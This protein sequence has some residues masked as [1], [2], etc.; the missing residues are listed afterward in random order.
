M[1]VL[2]WREVKDEEYGV[3][4]NPIAHSW[5]PRLFKA[6]FEA[7]GLPYRYVA[8]QCDDNE[9][10][11]AIAFLSTRMKGLNVTAP[12]KMRV[13]L[14]LGL[15]ASNSPWN[16]IELQDMSDSNLKKPS[17]H[18]SDIDGLTFA[19]ADLDLVEIGEWDPQEVL[20]EFTRSPKRV[21]VLG[22]GGAAQAACSAADSWGLSEVRNWNRKGIPMEDATPSPPSTLGFD[23]VINATGAV[24]EIEWHGS[25]TAFDMS[26]SIEPTP[27]VMTAKANGWAAYDGRLMLLHQAELSYLYWFLTP[28]PIEAMREALP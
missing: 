6:A 14:A 12:F 17:V 4:G 3:I 27:F 16:V 19:L 22:S 26:Y 28:A 21:L 13:D 8:I 1:A 18:N 23:L 11:E 10:E 15:E 25:G 5:S 9:F 20:P 24:P 7:A 2:N